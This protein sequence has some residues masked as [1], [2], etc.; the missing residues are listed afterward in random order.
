MC[1]DCSNVCARCGKNKVK[2]TLDWCEE[3][4]KLCCCCGKKQK[5]DH[6]LCA[7]C[8]ESLMDFDRQMITMSSV[9]ST[10]TLARM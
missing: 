5:V 8:I 2:N 4:E 10:A 7:D 9:K 6:G 3:C 1:I